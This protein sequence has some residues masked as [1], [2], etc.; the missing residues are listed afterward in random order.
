[1]KK[2]RIIL[3][4]CAAATAAAAAVC[5]VLAF[6]GFGKA[7]EAAERADKAVAAVGKVY[8]RN[9]FPSE[10]NIDRAGTNALWRA[11]WTKKLALAI[12]EGAYPPA[13]GVTPGAFSQMREKAIEN[14]TKAA[15]EGE[16]GKPVIPENFA[17]GFERYSSGVPAEKAHVERLVRQLKAMEQLVGVIYKAGVVC[18]EAAGR[19]VFEEGTPDDDGFS[20]RTDRPTTVSGSTITL[21]PLAAPKGAVPLQRD[22]F[23]LQFTAREGALTAILDDI[24]AMHPFAM[25]SSLSLE[26]VRPDVVFPDENES[27]RRAQAA[28]REDH[29]R[30]ARR[31]RRGGAAAEEVQAPAPAAQPLNERPAPR[32]S[33]LVS[34]PLRE[35]PV[36][37]LMTV[38]FYSVPSARARKGAAAGGSADGEED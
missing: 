16:D 7:S 27:E 23:A 6:L 3:I 17:F 20:G 33:R 10:E 36:R 9:P 18:F 19:E 11:E 2:S 14:M 15:P 35:A 29:P 22:R 13:R 37:V 4:S 32:S 31:N 28:S 38:D 30:R 34:G 25:V 21:P 26:K 24:D 12:D 5:V 1:M 8:A